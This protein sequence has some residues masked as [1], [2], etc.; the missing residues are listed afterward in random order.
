MKKDMLLTYKNYL[1]ALLWVKEF[2]NKYKD[3]ILLK[4]LKEELEEAKILRKN[5]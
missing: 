4:I 5:Q 3:E 2:Q 1:Y